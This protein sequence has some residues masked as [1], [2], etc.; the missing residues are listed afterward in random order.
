MVLKSSMAWLNS[1]RRPCWLGLELFSSSVAEPPPPRD[2]PL[3][4]LRRKRL[5]I[6]QGDRFS[7]PANDATRENAA[8]YFH[9][10]SP[11]KCI[12]PSHVFLWFLKLFKFTFSS[13]RIQS[14]PLERE[15]SFLSLLLLVKLHPT[16]Q[17]RVADTREVDCLVLSALALCPTVRSPH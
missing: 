4:L 9:L 15:K 11:T 5:V 8:A 1:S 7:Y 10:K 12:C 6:L 14:S 13:F 17:Y 16:R 3:L 2:P